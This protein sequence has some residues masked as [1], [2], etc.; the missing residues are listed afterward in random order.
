MEDNGTLKIK[1][2]VPDGVATKT[3]VKRDEIKA[4][5]KFDEYN[6][7]ILEV[8]GVPFGGPNEGRDSD[9][10]AFHKGTDIWLNIGD[11][12]PVT[13][14]HGY[15][16]DDPMDW[17]D[18][19]VVIGMAK[20]IHA[21]KRG[22][23][24]DVRLDE[25]EQLAL[26]ILA[27]PQ[28]A[29]ASSGAVGHLVRMGKADMIDVWPVGE[30]ALFDTN[31]WRLPANDYAV[32]NAKNETLQ[33]AEVQAEEAKTEVK[34]DEFQSNNESL[35]TRG[36][37]KMDKELE[38]EVKETEV[39]ET[40][41]DID[42]NKIGEMIKGAVA[43]IS[44]KVEAMEKSINAPS[45]ELGGLAVGNIKKVTE[46]GFKEDAT[47]SFM[48]WIKTGDEIAAKGAL[49]EGTSNEGGYIVPDDFY[50]RI[51]EKRDYVSVPR[52]AG[53]RVISTSRDVMKIP[54]EGTA[55][56]FSITS[57]EGSYS[58]SEPLIGEVS[59]TI[60][61]FT[62]LVKVSEELLA[63]QAANLESWLASHLARKWG[64][65]ENQYTINGSGS[66][67]PQ[68]ILYGGTAGL[69]LDDTNTISA[70]EIPELM[71]KLKSPYHDGAVWTM[72]NA[73]LW[74]L[75]GLASSSVFVLNQADK[76]GL[77]DYLMWGKPVFVD[78]NMG[79][80]TTTAN[81]ALA[82]GNWDYYALVERQ[83]MTVRRNEALYMASGQVGIFSSVRFGGAVL[84]AE[85]FQ[86][87]TTA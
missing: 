56:S 75:K 78:D 54:V 85:A 47:K 87:A 45:S 44:E 4:L 24:F 84:Q 3:I 37:T 76:T 7:P 60:Y 20:Y 29:R 67:Q 86:Y 30:L 16:P 11:T 81:K 34:Q 14:Y 28:K 79:S 57:E 66:S 22:H 52:K 18:R 13:Y 71:G 19:P 23:W 73:T 82:F 63:D 35:K 42:Y 83:G 9:G 12:V 68:G 49:Q 62:N 55:A 70:A 48:H 77:N 43:P 31:E 5:R 39:K 61:K 50:N 74:Y 10:E 17:Q 25:S 80:Y 65:T 72:E 41:S 46:L 38:T 36:E 8:L 2:R 33:K 1:I 51:V 21:D 53:A 40:K 69:T 26:R 27:D 15:G 6:S 59:V 32:V 64:L 58:E